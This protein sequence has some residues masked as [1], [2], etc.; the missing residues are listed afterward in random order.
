MQKIFIAQLSEEAQK[1]IRLRLEK[2]KTFGDMTDE[3]IETAMDDKINII[4]PNIEWEE[5]KNYSYELE[6]YVNDDRIH[7]HML[8]EFALYQEFRR[9][10]YGYDYLA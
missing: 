8:D 2:L 7:Q 3:D 1:D 4:V 10:K 9:V 6:T 5:W